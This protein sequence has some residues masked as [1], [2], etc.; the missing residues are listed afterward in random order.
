MNYIM[1]SNDLASQHLMEIEE[2][3]KQQQRFARVIGLFLLIFGVLSFSFNPPLSIFLMVV[4]F[5]VILVPNVTTVF[6]ILI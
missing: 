3:K 2:K 4:S 5:L 6:N 1:A